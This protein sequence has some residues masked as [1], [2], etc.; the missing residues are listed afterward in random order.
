M[1]INRGLL[2]VVAG[3]LVLGLLYSRLSR[4]Q[5]PAAETPA[6]PVVEETEPVDPALTIVT[7]DNGARLCPEAACGEGSEIARLPTG[8]K[9]L[10]TDSVRVVQPAVTVTWYRI[11]HGEKIGYVSIFDTDRP[12]P[13]LN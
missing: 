3:L 10:P 4:E 8:A 13:K 5:E 12:Q 7:P 6:A 2:A 11:E 1:S 9:Y